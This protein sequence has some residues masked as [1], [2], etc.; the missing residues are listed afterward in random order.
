MS[1]TLIYS[2]QEERSFE[3]LTAA[4]KIAEATGAAVKAVSINNDVLANAL[5]GRGADVY[6]INNAEVNLFD[7][8]AVAR[9]LHEAAQKL[10]T[11]TV[12]LSS[13]RRG[14][15]LAGSLAQEM[16]AGCLT[17]VNQILVEQ[18]E[19]HCVRN[20]LGGAT[21]ATQVIKTAH[22]V[23]AISPKSVIALEHGSGSVNQLEVNVKASGIKLIEARSKVGDTV[24][25]D[26][27]DVLIAVG[28]GL[29]KQEDLALV[30]KL[31]QL[32]GGEV[33]CSKPVATDRKWLSE[34]RIIG[35]S[36]KKCKPELAILMGISGQVQFVVGIRDAKIIIAINKDENAGIMQMADYVMVADIREVLPELL[37]Q[38]Q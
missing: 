9:A 30:E 34:E 6:K 33:A 16:K 38:L 17:D 35:L 25:I 31:A 3:L 28:Q 27:A 23:L 36:G 14:K 24:D 26:A 8:A 19:I 5:A 10:E 4:F 1:G 12:I 15:E 18:G 2:E 32:L 37:N 29:E 20:A 22:R 7:S 21:V 13:N 11:E